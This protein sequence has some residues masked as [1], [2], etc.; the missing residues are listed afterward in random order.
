MQYNLNAAYDRERFKA[1]V[2][3]LLSKGA[4]VELTE[5]SFRSLNQNSYLHLLIGIVAMETGNTL[6]DTKRC[7]FK[8][9][10]NPGIFCLKRTDHLGNTIQVL[11]SSA[12]VSKEEMST[13]IDRFKKWGA[14]NGIYMPSPEDESILKSIEIEMGKHRSM[15]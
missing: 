12:Q 10:V 11:R 7:Y 4:V 2:E 9:L 15:L 1:R 5:R 6:E 3:A 13:A 14:D 8:E